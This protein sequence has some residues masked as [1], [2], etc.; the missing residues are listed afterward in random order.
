MVF[1]TS[2][3]PQSTTVIYETSV[4][5]AAAGTAAATASPYFPYATT[6]YSTAAGAQP[7]ASNTAASAPAAQ[8][9]GGG[10]GVGAIVGIAIGAIAVIL[11]VILVA[12]LLWRRRRKQPSA[13]PP[14]TTTTTVQELGANNWRPDV[15][16]EVKPMMTTTDVVFAPELSAEQ[17]IYA[18]GYEKK[19]LIP[20]VSG[21]LRYPPQQL[22]PMQPNSVH[23]L[24]PSSA[25]TELAAVIPSEVAGSTRATSEYGPPYH[26]VSEVD[27]TRH[28]H[29]T[30]PVTELG[31]H[32]YEMQQELSASPYMTSYAPGT[33]QSGMQ[34]GN[35]PLPQ[36]L[37]QQFH[38]PNPIPQQPP[39]ERWLDL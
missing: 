16:K 25:N 38:S 19:P 2:Q 15:D 27:S 5:T 26:G 23:Q 10:L 13:L 24:S 1:S 28:S 21:D 8:N 4:L 14:E 11:I 6:I 9:S 34:R 31:S 35:Y 12:F 33:G 29:I 18:A 17:A 32:S 36:L 37:E 7:V 3:A 39:V 20:E 30:S 22:S